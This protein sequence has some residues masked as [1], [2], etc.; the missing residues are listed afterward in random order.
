MSSPWVSDDA[1]S[2]RMPSLWQWVK[3]GA[4]FTL[5]AGVAFS[6]LWVVY[7]VGVWPFFVRGVLAALR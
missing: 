3:A 7:M 4:G 6:A 1:I 2:V 5:G